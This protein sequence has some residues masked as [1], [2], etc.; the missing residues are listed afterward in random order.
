ML[1]ELRIIPH[2]FAIRSPVKSASES[3]VGMPAHLRWI[4]GIDSPCIWVAFCYR[5]GRQPRPPT[6]SPT[7]PAS[8]PR[9]IEDKTEI[10]DAW[11]D[12][13]ET[14]GITSGRV[15]PSGW[16]SGSSTR[17]PRRGIDNIEPYE[18]DVREDITFRL[19]VELRREL[20]LAE[21]Q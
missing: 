2:L 14:A 6:L 19:P 7:A 1:R 9:L 21:S 10:D 17:V 5:A 16:S 12:G 3:V 8:S 18:L 13:V 15:A 11:L 20:Q 4:A